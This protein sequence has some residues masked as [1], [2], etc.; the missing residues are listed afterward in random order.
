MCYNDKRG[1][2]RQYEIRE[3]KAMLTDLGRLLRKIRIDHGEIL[4]NM[5]DRFGVTASY[6]S[7]VENG[8]RPIPEAWEGII[9]AEYPLDQSQKEEL[10]RAVID[11]IASINLDMSSAGYSNKEVAF[12]F[13][14]KVVDLPEE[15]LQEIKRILGGE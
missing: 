15:K 8:K 7:A 12:A 13:A 2:K 1:G 10:H 3:E 14:R 4:K 5:A 6:L 9:L 11:S